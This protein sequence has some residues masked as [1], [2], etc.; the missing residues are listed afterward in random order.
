MKCKIFRTTG[1]WVLAATLASVLTYGCS[2][3]AKST[4]AKGV[5]YSVAYRD[6]DAK[7][8][9]FTRLNSASAVPGG[10]G[11]WNVDAYGELTSDFLIITRPQH[12][13]LGPEVIPVGN[14]VDVQFGDGGIKEVN[15]NR[16]MASR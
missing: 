4:V 14:L 13:D 10:N 11:S 12:R 15:E 16:P 6:V 1:V 9:G 3:Q 8:H 7:V 2:R 5:I